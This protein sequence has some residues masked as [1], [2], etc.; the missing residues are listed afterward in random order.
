MAD[1][2]QGDQYKE[3]F[4]PGA[5]PAL[6]KELDAALAG[7]S[8]DELYAFD[9][10][11]AQGAE[12][13]APEPGAKGVRRG[14]VVSVGKDEVFIDLGGK[15]QGVVSLLQF[16]EVKVGDE[17]D[18]T[19]E[20]YDPR[21][22]I[23]LLNRKGVLASNVSWENLEVG[24]IIEGM[25]TGM[26]KGGLEM[27]IKGMRAFMPSGQV[28]LYFQKDI[29]IFL[30]QKVTVEVTQ[31]D[32]QAKNLI[33]SRRNVLERE[34][35]EARTKLMA[36]LAE[37]QMR[38]GV[39]RNV[40]DFGAFIDLGGVDGLL[41]VS[42]M[43]HRRGRQPG[44]F[45]KN[46]DLVDV[47]V[48]KIDKATGKISLSLKQAMTDPWAGAETRYAT[49]TQLT[50]RVTRVEP[51]GAFIEVEEGLEGLLPVS[52]MSWQRIRHPSD[53]VKEGD[54]IKLVVLSIDP[55]AKRMSFSLKQAGPDPWATIQD[56]YATDM[57]VAGTVTRV[58]D[59][60]AFV[61][62]EPGLEGLVHISELAPNRVRAAGDVVKP[63]QEVQVRVLEIDKEAR[64]ISLSIRR[65]VEA[66]APAAPA[67]AAAVPAAQAKKKKRPELR[68][69]L[70]WN[71]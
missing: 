41:H 67:N 64:R 19:V 68:G 13:A 11:Q 6:D 59:F 60:G 32:R 39:V 48:I 9:K 54:T 26:N 71:W 46:G 31:F 49:G 1:Q 56:R 16:D 5:D 69:G 38:R 43:S 20:K 27:E 58:V 28:D 52:E 63:G 29:S 17:F 65:S 8:M 24:Q 70:D 62:L 35:E 47:K 36:E 61:E 2:Q 14:K 50:G 23:L 55:T 40:T 4:R 3:K 10:P 18:F 33:V 7:V 15:S 42:E 12:A 22:G 44:E 57:V 51:F 30:G 45:V 66:A 21:E 25:V 34:K 53:V 37:G